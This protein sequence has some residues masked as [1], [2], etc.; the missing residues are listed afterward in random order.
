MRGGVVWAG[1][2]HCIIELALAVNLPSHSDAWW[3]TKLLGGPGRVL[4]IQ[5][6]RPWA[7]S[8]D[9]HVN[10]NGTAA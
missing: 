6:G 7:G 9:C 5:V 8:S 2:C 4:H 10:T 1:Q 3:G